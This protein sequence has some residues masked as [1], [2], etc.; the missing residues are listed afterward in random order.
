M[1]PQTFIFFGKSGSGKGTQ[2]ELLIKGLEEKGG[3]T[4]YIETGQKFREFIA[5]EENYASTIT[6]EILSKGGLMPVFMPIWLWTGELVEKFDGTQ[7]L[8]LDGLCRR[9]DEAPV[10]DSALQFYKRSRPIVI[11]VNVSDE[12]ALTRLRARGRSDDTEEYLKT[13]LNW[14]EW[15]VKPAMAFFHEHPG[16]DFLEINGEQSIEDVQKE[17]LA[18]ISNLG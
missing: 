14:F 11:Y 2:A 6:R 9:V 18:K 7:H 5:R 16:Y 15:N 10:L 12:W 8:V 4:L 3:E 17:I 13:R 1:T